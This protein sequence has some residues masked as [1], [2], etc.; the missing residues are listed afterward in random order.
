[1][2]ANYFITGIDTDAGKSVVTGVMARWLRS[3]GVRVIT[4]KMAQTGNTESSEDIAAHRRIMGVA[5]FPEDAEG[6]TC[7]YIFPFPAAPDLSARLA[8]KRIEFGVIR[9]ATEQLK[10]RY[11]CVLTEGVGGLMVPLCG[12]R[13]VADY[14]TEYPC[15]VVLV[16]H[17]RLGSVNHALLSLEV[18]RNRGIRVAALVYNTGLAA[19]PV[20]AEDTR[21][22]LREAGERYFPGIPL[23]DF[24]FWEEGVSLPD[25]AP[26][27]APLFGS[28]RTFRMSIE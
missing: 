12:C 11:E 17:G 22:T 9:K 15:P 20:I 1:M 26:D 2:E 3:K 10:E 6:A 19:D 13:T 4:Q 8:G 28:E 27:F 23:I 21:R 5:A 24:P 16:C 25:F 7:P 18:C 14:L